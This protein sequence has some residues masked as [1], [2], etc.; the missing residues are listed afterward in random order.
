MFIR[1]LFLGAREKEGLLWSGAVFR[2][3]GEGCVMLGLEEEVSPANEGEVGGCRC[4][5]M[6][7]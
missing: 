4:I 5:C 6:R 1:E 3:W 7:K 2:G